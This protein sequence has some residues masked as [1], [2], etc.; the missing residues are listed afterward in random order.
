MNYAKYLIIFAAGCAVGVFSTKK[1]YKTKYE[2]IV[3]EE[4]ESIK[5]S[6]SQKNEA[7]SEEKKK[8]AE[9]A[10]EKPDITSYMAKVNECGYTNYSSVSDKADSKDERPYVISPNEFGEFDDYNQITLTYYADGVLVDGEDVI[11]NIDDIVG[12]DALDQFGA[13]EDDAVHVRNDRLRCD[14]EI[15]WDNDNYSDV[16]KNRPR[17]IDLEEDE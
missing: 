3:K 7:A 8:V 6:F 11:G 17:Q 14:Y 1:Y 4:I 16:M 13:Y 10:K 5:N 2:E 9:Q 15:L 12:E